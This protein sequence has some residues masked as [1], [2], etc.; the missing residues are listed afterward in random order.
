MNGHT[1]LQPFNNTCLN[2]CFSQINKLVNYYLPEDSEYITVEFAK[3][4]D[5]FTIYGQFLSASFETACSLYLLTKDPLRATSSKRG[6]KSLQEKNN[7]VLDTENDLCATL[8]KLINKFREETYPNLYLLG[9][10]HDIIHDENNDPTNFIQNERQ[11][12]HKIREEESELEN[13]DSDVDD[14]FID[15]LRAETEQ[16][17]ANK[18]KI[19]SK[20]LSKAISLPNKKRKMRSTNDDDDD[21]NDE[22][23]KHVPKKR[24]KLDL[25]F[26]K[27]LQT[28]QFVVNTKNKSIK[29]KCCLCNK[30]S[31]VQFLC[32]FF[33][34]NFIKACFSCLSYIENHEECGSI[35]QM[36]KERICPPMTMKTKVSKKICSANFRPPL[37][38]DPRDPTRHMTDKTFSDIRRSD[39][40]IKNNLYTEDFWSKFQYIDSDI[41]LG[42]K[43]KHFQKPSI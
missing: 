16:F 19:W 7:T 41:I 40:R 12:F 27:I 35:R 24:Q 36:L 43:S 2:L 21:D 29:H 23:K 32:E 1:F 18:N 10:Q 20:Q 33:E 28:Y 4:Y 39:I 37:L 5:F 3:T 15:D 8:T 22:I 14:E 30:K 26:E 9:D 34:K 25:D 17:A 13:S 38:F 31:S 11:K 6:R 42:N